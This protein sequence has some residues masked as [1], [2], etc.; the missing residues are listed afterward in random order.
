M[1]RTLRMPVTPMLATSMFFSGITY[2][3]TIPYASL[4]G[5]DTLGMSPGVFATIM[6]IGGVVGTLVSL[7][8]GYISDK[9]KDRR[10]LLLLSTLAGVAANFTVY[11]VP[12]QF[13]FAFSAIVLM[14]LA[15][16]SFSQC[17]AY[18]RVF[19]AKNAP[20]RADF[21]VTTLRS[22]FTAAWVIVPPL[23]G[24]V[25]AEFSIFNVYLMA[26]LAYVVI[27][28][29]FALMMVDPTTAVQMPPPVRAEGASLLSTFALPL[30]TLGGLISLA[31][32]TAAARILTFTVPLLIVT[33]LGGSLPDVGFY[34]AI[35]AAIEVPSLLIWGWLGMRFTK[36]ILLAS[37]GVILAL[38]MLSAAMS[39]SLPMLYWLLIL[40]GFATAALMGL[41]ISYVQ[42]A[43]KGRV[44]L[45]TSLLDVIAIS[46]NLMGATA[47]GV[48]TSGG[49][50]R[51]ALMVG[52]GVAVLGV[53]IMVGA[54]VKRLRL[55]PVN[56]G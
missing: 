12:T 10:G 36:E 49:D 13:G 28:A 51:F 4:V 1:A 55:L 24:W 41:N 8:L 38:F 14:P 22:V 37:A 32:M 30:S 27:G 48:L 35:T 40:N 44:G 56:G 54:N 7:F 46:A 21:M 19:Y 53:V 39:Q 23:A 31:V 34:A 45:S 25:A 6:A 29:I 2:A 43:I 15:G 18:I 26:A 50:Y 33:N 42:E 17:F 16:A 47:F 5:V 3:A 9:I 20:A 52:A 11:A